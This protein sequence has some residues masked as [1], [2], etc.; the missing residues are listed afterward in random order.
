MSWIMRLNKTC[1]LALQEDEPKGSSYK[2]RQFFDSTFAIL[3]TTAILF[4][5]GVF[6]TTICSKPDRYRFY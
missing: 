2:A 4:F 3:A 1:R 5:I 6:D